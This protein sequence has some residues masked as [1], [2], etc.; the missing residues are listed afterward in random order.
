[1]TKYTILIA[2][3]DE[4]YAQQLAEVLQGEE[5]KVLMARDGSEAIKIFENHPIDLGLLD[6]SMPGVDGMGI[7]KFAMDNHFSIPLI[8]ITGHA[9]IERAVA[10]TKMGAY[11]FMEKP[12]SLD[13][14]LISV[15]RALEKSILERR[16]RWMAEDLSQ[17]YKMVGSSPVM[18]QLYERIDKI[19]PAECSVLI[20]GETGT[21]KELVAMAIHMQSHRRN[22]PFIKVNCA[23]L[24]S[25]LIESE[26]FGHR[27][28]AFTGAIENKPGKFDAAHRGTLFLDEIGDMSPAAQAK[29]L[30]T[31]QEKEIEPVGS[32][33]SHIVD[34]RIIAATNRDLHQQMGNQSFRL[35]LYYRLST[36]EIL[37]PPLRE[38]REDIIPLANHFL[39]LFCQENNRLI[40][41]FQAGALQQLMN[42]D[43]PGNVRQLRSLVERLC[44]FAT[45][46]MISCKNVLEML[47]LQE[48]RQNE[49]TVTP[50][51]SFKKARGN[52]ERKFLKR[53]LIAHRWNISK[54]AHALEMDR[55][56]L[57]KKIKQLNI[58]QSDHLV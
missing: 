50:T 17:R 2:E 34:V 51:T 31:L 21:G 29:I 19:A 42:Y 9:S 14:L 54:T 26:L 41:G 1:M 39:K 43:W 46:R 38:R 22:S 24:P 40:E 18:L 56:N 3:D 37:I 8:M 11:D 7:L 35:D 52:F 32:H 53:A 5:Y 10:A 16:S 47:P 44:L 57:Y 58:Q 33:Q 23:A 48:E 13:R 30:R 4:N 49:P 27:R 6:L 45:T 20:T 28:G 25:E 55:T 36:I 15:Q 12:V